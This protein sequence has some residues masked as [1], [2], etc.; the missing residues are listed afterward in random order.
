MTVVGFAEVDFAEWLEQ[1]VTPRIECV[2]NCKAFQ[3]HVTSNLCALCLAQALITRFASFTT[4]D[5]E[6]SGSNKFIS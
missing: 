1:L 4:V 2:R 5:C 3:I 6:S